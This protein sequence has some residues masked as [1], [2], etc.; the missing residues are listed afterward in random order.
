MWLY[1][2]LKAHDYIVDYNCVSKNWWKEAGEGGELGEEEVKGGNF[3]YLLRTIP[4]K[5]MKSV[6]Y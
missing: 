2:G 5:Y 6:L 3:D 4:M 1:S